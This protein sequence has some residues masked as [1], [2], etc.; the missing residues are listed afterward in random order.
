MWM[1]ES[2]SIDSPLRESAMPKSYSGDLRERA[3]EVVE[4]EGASRR[5]GSLPNNPLVRATAQGEGICQ[6]LQ[7]C[8]LYFNMSGNR[9]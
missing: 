8:R 9:F 2:L 4:M 3:I 5:S 1:S 6:L 7:A